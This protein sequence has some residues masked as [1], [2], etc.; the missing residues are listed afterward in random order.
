VPGPT[1]PSE[2]GGSKVDAVVNS[3]NAAT[4]QRGYVRETPAGSSV[5]TQH[6][7]VAIAPAA[8]FAVASTV[9][10]ATVTASLPAISSGT[11]YLAGFSISG[12]GASVPVIV[13]ATIAGLATNNWDVVI[14]VPSGNLSA[15]TPVIASLVNPIPAS[16]PSTA[17]T[18]T[19]PS[20]GTGNA[21]V[22]IAVW[23]FKS[24]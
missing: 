11:N 12:T 21:G 15:I 13:H 18:L 17:I 6:L 9:T 10:P 7:G 24:L 1:F 3:A 4:M 14:S 16:A 19:V 22:S 20:F 5:D 8:V 2:G 23:G